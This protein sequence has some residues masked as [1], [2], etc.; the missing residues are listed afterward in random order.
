MTSSTLS[1]LIDAAA[2]GDDRIIE[3]T[4]PRRTTFGLMKTRPRLSRRG[5]RSPHSPKTQVA[6]SCLGRLRAVIC[7]IVFASGMLVPSGFAGA[8]TIGQAATGTIFSCGANNFWVQAALGTSSPSYTI[9]LGGGVIDSWRTGTMGATP[10]SQI[11]LLV[12]QA[13]SSTTYRVVAFDTEQLPNPLPVGNVATFPIRNG[14]P[15]PAGSVLG[16]FGT[17]V[18]EGC[19]GTGGGQDTVAIGAASSPTQA[20]T[21]TQTMTASSR[22]LNV[23]VDLVQSMD[24]TLTASATPATIAA[25]GV[26]LLGFSISNAGPSASPATLVDTVPVGLSVL[27][28]FIR[29][30]SCTASAQQVVCTS[31]PLAVGSSTP[32]GLVV[33]SRV[34]GAFVNSGTLTSSLADPNPTNNSATA[35]LS[36]NPIPQAARPRCRVVALRRVPLTQAKAVLKALSCRTGRVSRRRSVRIPKGEVISTS[37]G[38]GIRPPGTVVK[39]VQS[40]GKPKDRTHK[41]S[42]P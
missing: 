29:S 27:A 31:A 12:L 4:H 35:T 41:H 39:I 10:G 2:P 37:P 22:L 21:Y 1:K 7:G 13:T 16:L 42:R 23:E 5:C 40:S 11:T 15:V 30:G 26:G 20:A 19:A 18:A 25:G 9:P 14:L 33:V 17:T 34:P 3:N 24:L 32:A 28:A 6:R 36:V 38:P 8:V